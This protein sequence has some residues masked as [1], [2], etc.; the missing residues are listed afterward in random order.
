MEV[1][2]EEDPR[3]ATIEKEILDMIKSEVIEVQKKVTWEDIAGLEEAKTKLEE[4]VVI[5]LLR[6]DL[7]T[8]IRAAPK[9]ILLFG[10]PGTG[11]TL[12]GRCIASQ[13][14]AT[15]FSISASSLTSKWIGQGEKLVK[16]L[17]TYARVM[18][19]SVIFMDEIDSI[20][21]KRSENEHESSRRLKTEF[22]VQLDG[23]YKTDESDRI[24]IVA[25]TNRPQ[26]LDEAVRRRFTQ[27]LYIPLPCFEG[28]KSLVMNLMK[29]LKHSMTERDF[30]EVG[31][32]T[33][34]YSGA[35]MQTLVKEASMEVIRE[36][37]KNHLM[38][39]SE[40]KVSW[41]RGKP[42]TNPLIAQPSLAPKDERQRL[43]QK[44]LRRQTIS[45]PFRPHSVPRVE[46]ALRIDSLTT[47][48]HQSS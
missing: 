39:I 10:P 44:L 17:F 37:S 16:A 47:L 29:H 22:L 21:M 48:R 28:R 3:L 11:K 25:A 5:P 46:F 14:N 30:D 7:F 20:L 38:N 24:L 8:G 36:I 43:P 1:E 26:E 35:D 42:L 33:E 13:S 45:Q 18:Q 2:P 40:E 41:W 15:F 4:A 12:I 27:K 23:A 9:G 32:K 34:G 31:E 19:P 6:P